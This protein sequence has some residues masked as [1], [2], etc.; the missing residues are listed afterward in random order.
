MTYHTTLLDKGHEQTEGHIIFTTK[1][2]K[3]NPHIQGKPIVFVASNIP[4]YMGG[5]F[6]LWG[7]AKDRIAIRNP[8]G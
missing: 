4:S 1:K 5:R 6:N 7:T 2:D 8:Y 3:V